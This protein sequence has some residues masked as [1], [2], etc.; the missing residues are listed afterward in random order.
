[1]TAFKKSKNHTIAND[2]SLSVV[3]HTGTAFMRKK[4]TEVIKDNSTTIA[5]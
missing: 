2:T 5:D 4:L 3:A 1:M